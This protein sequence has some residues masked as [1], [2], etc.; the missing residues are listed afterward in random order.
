[1]LDKNA[2]Q[3]QTLD[4]LSVIQE[5]LFNAINASKKAYEYLCGHSESPPHDLWDDDQCLKDHQVQIEQLMLLKSQC[6]YW[7]KN[8][9]L[10]PSQK[11]GLLQL[12]KSIT[13]C[14]KISQYN[15]FKLHK[16]L[17]LISS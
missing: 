9:Y 6:E 5:R 14:E 16:K 8:S 10:T 13:K 12:E 2:Q 4:M 11:I 7:R 15:I 3:Y 1:M 17:G